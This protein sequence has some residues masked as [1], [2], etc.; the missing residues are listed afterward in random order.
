MARPPDYSKPD[1]YTRKA[2]DRG[3]AAR[4]VFKLEEVDE[5]EVLLRPGMRV[6]DL[7]SA[8]GSWMQYAAEKVGPRGLVVGVDLNPLE[9]QLRPNERFLQGDAFALGPEA[10]L[11]PTFDLVLSDLMPHTIGHKAADHYRS[12]AMAERALELADAL[13]RPGGD[14]LVKVFQGADF[15]AFRNQLRE[16]FRVVKIKKPKSSRPNSRELYLLGRDR[17]RKE[18]NHGEGQ[19]RQETSD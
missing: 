18:E 3:Y 11:S 16:R 10:F 2:H 8:P 9:R 12:V 13:L 5:K 7:G 17:K 19:N 4:S 6:L 1:H 15:E 14:F